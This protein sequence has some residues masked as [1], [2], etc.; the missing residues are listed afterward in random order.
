MEV[1][2]TIRPTPL[3]ASNTSTY[4]TAHLSDLF[5]A[6][7]MCSISGYQRDFGAQADDPK[8]AQSWEN[9]YAMRLNSANREEMRRKY[10]SGDWTS[11]SRPNPVAAQG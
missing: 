1:F 9:Q 5:F 3:S 6:A 8:Q 2:G 10:Q 11:E 7:C 4:L